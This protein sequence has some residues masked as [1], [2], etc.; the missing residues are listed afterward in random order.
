M[1]KIKNDII[2]LRSDSSKL[3][4]YLFSIYES[5]YDLWT[6]DFL[7]RELE[8]YLFESDDWLLIKA[9]IHG[10]LLES[11]K[12]EKYIKRTFSLLKNSKEEEVRKAAI[13]GLVSSCDRNNITLIELLKEI[14]FDKNEND[15]LRYRAIEGL[16]QL[17][18]IPSYKL[19]LREGF[20]PPYDE[21]FL[22]D[23]FIEFIKDDLER[24]NLISA[25]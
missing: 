24:F 3:S 23:G 17:N 9:A 22:I 20:I 11:N 16:L 2:K 12:S 19:N 4:T 8:K 13:L 10:L 5:N 18:G 14:G 21:E 6:N 7:I 25:E 1:E 15:F